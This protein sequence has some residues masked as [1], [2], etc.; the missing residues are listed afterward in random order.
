[1]MTWYFGIDSDLQDFIITVHGFLVFY[2]KSGCFFVL[3][4]IEFRYFVV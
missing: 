4:I 3:F 2:T 1:M